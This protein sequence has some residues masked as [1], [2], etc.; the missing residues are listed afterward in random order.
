[1]KANPNPPPL[2][3]TWISG[4]SSMHHLLKMRLYMLPHNHLEFNTG[5]SFFELSLNTF[6]SQF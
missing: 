2:K 5:K 3:D 6:I 1:M 4:F